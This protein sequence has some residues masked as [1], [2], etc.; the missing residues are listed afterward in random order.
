MRLLALVL[1]LLIAPLAGAAPQTKEQQKCLAG[2]AK[3][4]AGIAKLVS[5]GAS[6]CLKQAAA[7]ILSKL[8][9]LEKRTN[10]ASVAWLACHKYPMLKKIPEVPI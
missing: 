3:G 8:L 6:S 9:Y 4:A 7:W 2:F 10:I 1:V 5:K